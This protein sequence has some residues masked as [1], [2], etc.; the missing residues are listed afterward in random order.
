MLFSVLI[1]NYNNGLYIGEAIKSVIAQTYAD[2]EV[3]VVD[4]CSSD[5]S[6]TVVN[7]YVM[8]DGRIKF[9]K[10]DKNRGVGYTKKRLIDLASGEILGFLDSDD[11]LAD[12]ALEILIDAHLQHPECSLIYSKHYIC[13]SDL[14]IIKIAPSSCIIPDAST[15]LTHGNS[16]ILISHF[17]A[18]KKSLYLKNKP[19]DVSFKKAID[20]DLYYKL[21]EVGKILFVDKPL[22]YYRQ[23]GGSISLFKNETMAIWWEIKA[24]V[25]AYQRRK[26]MKDISNLTRKE[27][28]ELYRYFYRRIIP[29]KLA[30]HLYF[31]SFKYGFNMFMHLPEFSTLRFIYYCIKKHFY[32][33]KFQNKIL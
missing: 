17:A 20:K 2:W 25:K 7:E 27:I 18:F 24:K 8:K 33:H 6:V 4:D 26:R 22:Y 15:Y 5:D 32:P 12:E 10:N 9:Y 23:H 11:V 3:I 19:L 14:N 30:E 16:S 13:D 29:E 21:E 1:A 31:Q 28:K